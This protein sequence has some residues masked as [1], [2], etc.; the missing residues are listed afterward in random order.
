M[1]PIAELL[2]EW[3]KSN[4]ANAK[5]FT[6]STAALFEKKSLDCVLSLEMYK[7]GVHGGESVIEYPPE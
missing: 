6:L 4:L 3:T 5:G 1:P 2:R 7:E